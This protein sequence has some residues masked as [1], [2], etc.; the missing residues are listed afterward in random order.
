MSSKNLGKNFLS[1][2]EDH[3]IKKFK[4]NF[5]DKIHIVQ[6]SRPNFKFYSPISFNIFIFDY[7]IPRKKLNRLNFEKKNHQIY[8]LL[9]NIT[10]MWYDSQKNMLLSV[11]EF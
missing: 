10:V 3:Y 2:F 7:K 8:I 5:Y 6:E 1:I 4:L 11:K 9:K